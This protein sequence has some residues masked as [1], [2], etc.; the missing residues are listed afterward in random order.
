MLLDNLLEDINKKL[1]DIQYSIELNKEKDLTINR[2]HSEV[3]D[4]RNNLLSKQSDNIF[5]EIIHL[6]DANRKLCN[7]IANSEIGD[8]DIVIDYIDSLGHDL[9]DILYRNNV[10]E[11]ASDNNIFDSKSQT[12]VA[13]KET[14]NESLIGTRSRTISSGYHR[15]GEVL[16]KERIE[17]FRKGDHNI[18]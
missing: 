12:I 8:K 16:R 13:S 5:L 2:L 7:D 4:F 1:A 14:D 18:E 15:D 3:I 10:E 9:D 11:F 17:I 6:I